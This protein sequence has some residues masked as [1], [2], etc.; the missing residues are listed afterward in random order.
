MPTRVGKRLIN[1]RYSDQDIL[2]ATGLLANS[3]HSN[4][5]LTLRAVLTEWAR[6]VSQG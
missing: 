1:Q 5:I 6:D 4:F 2:E 3:A